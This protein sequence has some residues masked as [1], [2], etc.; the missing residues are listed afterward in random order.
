LEFQGVFANIFNHDQMLNGFSYL[1]NPGG[2]GALGGSAQE[3]TGGNRIVEL[4]ARVKF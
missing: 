2:W 3:Q 1:G 4:G